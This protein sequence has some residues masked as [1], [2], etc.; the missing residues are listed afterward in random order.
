MTD[1]I[2]HETKRIYAKYMTR[3][4]FALLES[5]GAVVYFTREYGPRGLKGYSTVMNRNKYAVIN[6]YLSP[7]EQKIV[8]GH[9][10]AHLI[11]HVDEILSSPVRALRDFNM[12]DNTGRIEYEANLF[13]ADFILNDD[14]VMEHVYDEDM[15]FFT[16]ASE[17]CVPS[18]LFAFKLYSMMRRGYEVRSPIDLDSQFLGK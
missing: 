3:D 17:L 11:L 6:A 8:A 5:I 15:N 7:A 2:F 12:W 9:E 16:I 4:P 13:L 18:P 1:F 10:A 14:E